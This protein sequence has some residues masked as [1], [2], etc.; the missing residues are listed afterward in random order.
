MGSYWVCQSHVLDF[1]NTTFNQFIF[2]SVAIKVRDEQYINNVEQLM[3]NTSNANILRYFWNNEQNSV[4]IKLRNDLV[5]Y[6]ELLGD[7]EIDEKLLTK[8][9]KILSNH[10]GSWHVIENV[11]TEKTISNLLMI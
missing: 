2:E 3:P 11:S 10:E 5:E 4:V 6:C 1:S 9:H 8:A 7:F